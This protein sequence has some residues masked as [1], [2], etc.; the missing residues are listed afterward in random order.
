MGEAERGALPLYT[1]SMNHAAGCGGNLGGMVT[2]TGG[3][4]GS[5][6]ADLEV[7]RVGLVSVRGNQ[8]RGGAGR[9]TTWPSFQNSGNRPLESAA[10]N[11]DNKTASHSP[12]A[13]RRGA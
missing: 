7:G 13:V 12:L 11:K 4:P 6:Y 3:L 9:G 1:Q 8:A 10:L 2:R 5:V